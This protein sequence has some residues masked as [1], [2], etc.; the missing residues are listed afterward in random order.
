MMVG[1][2]GHLYP[3]RGMEILDEFAELCSWADFHVVGGWPDDVA[4]WK[5]RLKE[6]PNVFLHGH[7]P[8]N[9][10]PDFLYA[11][12]VLIAPYQ[13][14][15]GLHG[16]AGDNSRWV[17][18]IKVFEYM[19]AGKP[20]IC[21]DHPVLREILTHEKTALLCKPT[22]VAAWAEALRRLGDNQDLASEIASNASEDFNRQYS[23]DARARKVLDGLTYSS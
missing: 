18:P 23:W 15:V 5:Q 4:F 19:A 17:C 7:V 11:M 2:I 22:D 12:D 1:Y 16:G 21:S 13:P 10:V 6:R 14:V 3:G 9:R 20:I 8:P